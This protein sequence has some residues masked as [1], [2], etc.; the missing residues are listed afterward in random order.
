VNTNPERTQAKK[1]KKKNPV[2]IL[3]YLLT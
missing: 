3:R 1:K 2:R